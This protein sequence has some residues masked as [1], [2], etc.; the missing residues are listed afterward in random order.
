MSLAPEIANT[1]RSFAR[2][3]VYV[4]VCALCYHLLNSAKRERKIHT[5]AFVYRCD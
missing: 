5:Y 3:C 1:L 2:N 4:S